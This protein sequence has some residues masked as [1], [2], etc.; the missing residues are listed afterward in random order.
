[1]SQTRINNER[2]IQEIVRE[3]VLRYF[4]ERSQTRCTYILPYT[5]VTCKH[6]SILEG[7]C[8]FHYFNHFKKKEGKNCS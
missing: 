8:R 1:M 4:E 6:N 2:L 5:G 3:E 7:L